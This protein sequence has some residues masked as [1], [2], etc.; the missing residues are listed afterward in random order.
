MNNLAG[1]PKDG[2]APARRFGGFVA[3]FVILC[4]CLCLIALWLLYSS[5]N[6]KTLKTSWYL[7][8]HGEVTRGIIAHM[9]EESGTKPGSGPVYRL[10]VEYDV[11]GKTYTVRSYYAYGNLAAYEVGDSIDVIYDPDDPGNAQVD[12]FNERWLDPILSTLPF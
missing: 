1:S 2:Q 10:V 8:T 4:G 3:F 5:N 11:D 7:Q 12:I 6:L 9:E